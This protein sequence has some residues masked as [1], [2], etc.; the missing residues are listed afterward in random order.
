M[1]SIIVATLATAAICATATA[2]QDQAP[3]RRSVTVVA[4]DGKFTPNRIEVIKDDLVR[5]TLRSEGAPLQ[6]RHR[7]LPDLKR[8]G[9]GQ[10]VTFEFR[11]DQVGRFTFYCNLTSDPQCAEMKG[12][13]VV[14]RAL[15]AAASGAEI[16]PGCR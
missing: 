7:R 6:L 8:A 3:N 4:K 15:R 14:S 9:A 11:A 10:T 1:R 5:I 16:D 12:T 2:A 13:L